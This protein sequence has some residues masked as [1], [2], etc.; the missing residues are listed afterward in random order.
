MKKMNIFTKIILI[1]AVLAGTLDLN[2]GIRRRR[3]AR[4]PQTTVPGPM[5]RFIRLV[6]RTEQQEPVEQQAVV[7]Q[8]VLEQPATEINFEIL[9]RQLADTEL[10]LDIINLII[11]RIQNY[12]SENQEALDLSELFIT[13]TRLHL[14]I[15]VLA[16]INV[17]KLNL[18]GNKIKLIPQNIKELKNL[19]YLNLNGN[20]II[21]FHSS[22]RKFNQ[23]EDALEVFAKMK[24]LRIILLQNNNLD[25]MPFIF[26]GMKNLEKL[27]IS[28]NPLKGIAEKF[29]KDRR[30]I[31]D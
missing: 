2:A 23:G 30:F 8:P 18:A 25:F 16:Q 15:P 24:N 1:C 10:K 11:E 26:L 3:E 5:D 27:D 17:R 14:I 20:N 19:N 31:K 12:N 13:D 22:F 9:I 6:S 4:R 7:A 28:G 21:Y 29:I